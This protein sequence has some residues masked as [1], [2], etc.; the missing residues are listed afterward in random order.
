MSLPRPIHPYHFQADL[1]WWDGLFKVD[2]CVCVSWGTQLKLVCI[3][4]LISIFLTLV[5]IFVLEK[6]LF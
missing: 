5:I 3:M 1:I 4:Y 2:L 6:N